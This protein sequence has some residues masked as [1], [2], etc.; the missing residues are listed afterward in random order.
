MDAYDEM[1]A[2]QKGDEPR[3][4]PSELTV[5]LERD[6]QVELDSRG[7]FVARLENMQA[8]GHAW[9][10]IAAV[11]ALIN[12]CDMLARRSNVE[13]SGRPHLDTIKES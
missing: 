12:Y 6:S 2:A 13:V 8:N 7:M 1:I 11:L 5:K 9:L 10:T 4:S 3:I